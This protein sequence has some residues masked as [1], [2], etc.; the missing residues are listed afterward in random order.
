MDAEIDAIDVNCNLLCISTIG[1]SIT[2]TYNN[3]KFVVR[4]YYCVLTFTTCVGAI[5]CFD[6]MFVVVGGRGYSQELC[7]DPARGAAC[8]GR[9]RR[10]SARPSR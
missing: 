10:A 2:G 7:T 8:S 9:A 1:I 6:A 4:D 3:F 5:S